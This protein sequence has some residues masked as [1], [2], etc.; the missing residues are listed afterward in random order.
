MRWDKAKTLMIVLFLL[1]NAFL[2]YINIIQPYQQ[3]YQRRKN[4][5]NMH[6][7]ALSQLETEHIVLEQRPAQYAASIAPV[8]L[9]SEPLWQP[10]ALAAGFFGV[11]EYHS[12]RILTLTG[13]Q[14]WRFTQGD[15][16]LEIAA[17]GR[18]FYMRNPAEAWPTATTF[19]LASAFTED[20]AKQMAD[21]FLESR[22]IS[23]PRDVRVSAPAHALQGAGHANVY[24]FV[25]C[26][27][28]DGAEVF[29][30]ELSLSVDASGVRNGYSTLR[31]VAERGTAL[32]TNTSSDVLLWLQGDGYASSLAL[33]HWEKTGQPLAIC[34]MRLGLFTGLAIA[35]TSSAI[36]AQPAWRIVLHSGETI[37]MNALNGE[38]FFP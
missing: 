35:N 21:K 23:L 8:L 12:E 2:G 11:S 26:L 31:S 22:H 10:E 25:W 5:A 17:D 15:E 28:V 34:E 24:T 6:Q 1:L 29:D 9:G 19:G 32:S 36:T 20:Q 7:W 30:I 18:W 33:A 27:Q 3:S 4:E 14:L 38:R 37:Y 16:L 13:D